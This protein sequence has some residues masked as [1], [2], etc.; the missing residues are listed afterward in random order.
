VDGTTE[1]ERLVEIFNLSD[2]GS[3]TQASISFSKSSMMD[4]RVPLSKTSGPAVCVS[5]RMRGRKRWRLCWLPLTISPN[6]ALMAEGSEEGEREEYFSR[7]SAISL[8]EEEEGR[9]KS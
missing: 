8:L 3:C 2:L 4:V 7:M 5:V 1:T 9:Q 6:T